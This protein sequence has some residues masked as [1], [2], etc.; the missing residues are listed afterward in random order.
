MAARH[1]LRMPRVLFTL[2]CATV[3]TCSA[4]LT[5]Q[6]L[7]LPSE[8]QLRFGGSINAS[9]EGWFDNP[10]G[11]HSFL[12][13]Y[14]SRNTQQTVDIPIGPNNRIEPGGPD[15]GQPTHF[16]PQRNVGMFTITVPKDFDPA[17]KITWTLNANGQATSIPFRLN[18][19]Y[20][21]SPLGV[22]DT[23]GNKPPIIRFAPEAPAIAGPLATLE[24]AQV[25]TT[26]MAK[27]CG[28]TK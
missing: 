11:T 17:A 15:R 14:F 18:P 3:L 21:I 8:P 28:R 7:Q 24:R 13:G 12:V 26:H 4:L 2:S 16:L 27:P 19:D 23:V 5:A 1:D 20:N 10:D 22:D 6:Q 9:F 25:R